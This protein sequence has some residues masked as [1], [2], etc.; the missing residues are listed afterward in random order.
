MAERRTK[1][2]GIRKVVGASMF[3]LWRMLSKD[4]VL[5]VFIACLVAIRLRTP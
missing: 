1:E 2:I 4:F 3:N 5:L